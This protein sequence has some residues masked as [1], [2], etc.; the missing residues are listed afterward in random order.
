MPFSGK[1]YRLGLDLQGGIELDYKV[2]L[3]MVRNEKDHNQAKEKEIIEGLKTIID[4]RI[5]ALNINDSEIN[6][7]S[8]GNEKHIIVQIPLK[9]N[10]SLENSENIKIAKEAIGKVVKIVFKERRKE[11]TEKD[12]QERKDIAE[13]IVE[14][15]KKGEIFS[16]VESKYKLNYENI[17]SGVVSS[18]TQVAKQKDGLE[19]KK[20]NEIQNINGQEGFLIYQK[21]DDFSFNYIFVNKM[22]S[23][24]KDAVDSKGR[25]LNDK[26]FIKAS[27]GVNNISQPVVEL[28]FNDEGGKIFGELSTRLVGEQ[29]AIFVGGELLTA[30][31]INEPIFGG[32][33]VITGRYTPEEAKKLAQDINTGVV[34][35]PIYLT[36]EKTID[37]KIG[38]EALDELIVA[39]GAGFLLMFIFLAIIYKASGIAA[40]LALVIYAILVLSIVK[41]FGMVLTLASIAG[42]I[43]SIGM[44]ID[45]NILIFERIKAE[46]A[47]GKS[48]KDSLEIGFK[49][50]WSAIW[51]SNITG[52]LI[53]LIL[54]IFGINL[55]KGFGAMLAIGIIVSLFTAMWVSRIFI[56]FLANSMK[57]KNLFIGFKNKK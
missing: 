4:K 6:D 19:E 32:R 56:A 41:M 17:N 22:P 46:L 57:D 38:A 15:L 21:K 49:S 1:D 5:E 55:I 2:D 30:P 37:S 31:N 50:S 43:L 47:L 28:A 16:L 35:A 39:G 7:A 44:A 54:F 8:Y 40:F 13:K 12:L 52:L 29:M 26:Y 9:G 27:V 20:V 48:M 33:A 25:V 53:A 18:I 34:P 23:E 45:A 14:E 11:V 51:D 42:L 3:E 24:W 36:S 10:D